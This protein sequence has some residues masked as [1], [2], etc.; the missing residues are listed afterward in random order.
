MVED[1]RFCL[2]PTILLWKTSPH[3]WADQHSKLGQQPWEEQEPSR[4]GDEGLS[5]YG[6][7]MLGD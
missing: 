1:V 6:V 7:V 5:L 4:W 2:T 3:G